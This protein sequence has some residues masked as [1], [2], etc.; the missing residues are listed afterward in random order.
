MQNSENDYKHLP[1]ELFLKDD[2][3]LGVAVRGCLP[4]CRGFLVR[5]HYKKDYSRVVHP[6]VDVSTAGEK[7]VAAKE[8]S[9]TGSTMDVG[10]VAVIYE[11]IS[12]AISDESDGSPRP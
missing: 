10:P 5:E 12:P 2:R 6:K 8:V 7:E 9:A 3:R 11:D 4:L 1:D